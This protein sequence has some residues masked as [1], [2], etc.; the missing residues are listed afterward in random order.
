MGGRAS[1]L[2]NAT[3]PLAA[4]V[5]YYGGRIAP[6]LLPL[7]KNMHAPILLFWGGKDKH[8]LPEQ[9][10]AVS[11]ALREAGKAYTEVVFS[12]GDHGFSCDERA[13]YN[14]KA[15]KEAWALTLEFLK[16]E[17]A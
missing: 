3:L 2:A 11:D 13:S 6:D 9:Y 5:S 14:P 16:D 15:A 8:I 10:R 7:A 1:Y 12:E 17:L 4:A